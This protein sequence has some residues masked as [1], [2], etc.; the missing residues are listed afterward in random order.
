MSRESSQ[1]F[2]L[3]RLGLD[4]SSRCEILCTG[5][6]VRLGRVLLLGRT[7]SYLRADIAIG[8]LYFALAFLARVEQCVA[9]TVLLEASQ[10]ALRPLEPAPAAAP[11]A[12][13]VYVSYSNTGREKTRDVQ[14]SLHELQHWW[15]M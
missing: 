9:I 11:T 4:C 5:G 14:L 10:I 13:V 3:Q 12:Q 2:Q 6:G 8:V 7:A 1:D 15:H